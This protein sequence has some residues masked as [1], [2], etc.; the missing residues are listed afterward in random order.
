M[1]CRR[2]S[3]GSVLHEAVYAKGPVYSRNAVPKKLTT[4]QKPPNET[5]RDS[6][7]I[8]VSRAKWNEVKHQISFYEDSMRS[9]MEQMSVP[10]A[11][12]RT[13]RELYSHTRTQPQRQSY[14]LAA[15]SGP[16]LRPPAAQIPNET[17]AENALTLHS[18]YTAHAN[19]RTR[20]QPSLNILLARTLLWTV[21]GHVFLEFLLRFLC[22]HYYF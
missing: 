16:V 11:E 18:Y 17:L 8:Q 7:L 4:A 15:K 13:C 5:H 3:W 10:R 20:N 1:F 12:L 9:M 22:L 14:A 6:E 21:S 2:R 19:Q